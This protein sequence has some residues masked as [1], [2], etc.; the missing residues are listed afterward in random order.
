MDR[1]E[2][3]TALATE[4]L[5]ER[6][7]QD[8]S[9]IHSAYSK[10]SPQLRSNLCNTMQQILQQVQLRQEMNQ[11]G[12]IASIIYNGGDGRIWTPDFKKFQNI[13]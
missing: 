6:F 12:S 2:T 4:Y 5:Q 8:L 11:K 7:A 13:L 1:R 3:L 9:L 10:S